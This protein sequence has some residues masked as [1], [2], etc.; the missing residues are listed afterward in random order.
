MN[1]ALI[2]CA[3]SG[4]MDSTVRLAMGSA[5]RIGKVLVTMISA[6]PDWLSRSTAGPENTAWVAA[7][8][9]LPAPRSRSA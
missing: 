9:T 4:A 8:M 5:V 2:A 1:T 6:I 3:M 7:Q